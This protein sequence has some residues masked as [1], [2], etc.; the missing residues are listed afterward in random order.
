MKKFFST[1]LPVLV[2]LALLLGTSACK[3]DETND[4][5][6]GPKPDP[7]KLRIEVSSVSTDNAAIN[8][9]TVYET[10]RYIAALDFAAGF[11]ARSI[12]GQNRAAFVENAQA[13]GKTLAEFIEGYAFKGTRSIPCPTLSPKSDYVVYAYGIDDEGN[14]TTEV[15]TEKF[16]TLAIP[17]GEQVDCTF[18]ILVKNITDVTADVSFIPSDESVYYFYTVTDKAGYDGLSADWNGYIYDLMVSH[19][20]ENLTLEDV[21]KIFCTCKTMNSKAKGLTPGTTYYACAVGVGMDALLVTDVAVEPFTTQEEYVIDYTFDTAVSNITSRG[22]DIAIQPHA[23]TALYY[24]NVM[25]RGDYDALGRDEEKIAAYFNEAMIAKRAAELGSYADF[26]PLPDYILSQCSDKPDSYTF[27]GL[28]ASTDYYVYAFWID[29]QT[30]DIASGTYFSEPFRTLDK[31]VSTATVTST[32]W[33]TDGDDWAALSP[34]GYGHFAGKAIL[35]ARLTPSSDAVHWYSN[36]FN[37][38]DL[39]NYSD[40]QFVTSLLKSPY[41]DKTAYNL[42][43]TVDWGGDYAIVSVAEDAAGN[44]S[45]VVKRPFK[46]EKSAAEPLTELPE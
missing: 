12:V 28:S 15:V 25:T 8:V 36:I 26:Y 20:T 19:L 37:A 6:P 17:N 32:L 42:S 43:Y 9:T 4:P 2:S 30:G 31:V 18:D 29:E 27:T 34:V 40:D 3:D 5:G 14:A 13:A 10:T 22:A 33:L 45:E 11:D 35:G 44:L 23:P 16:T 24:W 41:K 21:V 38:S 1:T 39:D 7:E 46:A